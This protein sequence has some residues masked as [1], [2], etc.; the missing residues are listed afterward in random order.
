MLPKNTL[1][2]LNKIEKYI[3][4]SN[5]KKTS[6]YAKICKIKLNIL[7]HGTLKWISMSSSIKYDLVRLI[8]NCTKSLALLSTIY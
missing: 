4:I 3:N 6:K 1:N 7:N 2:M 8:C 5:R